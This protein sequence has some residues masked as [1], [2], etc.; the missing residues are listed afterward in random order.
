DGLRRALQGTRPAHRNV[1]ALGQDQ[2]PVIQA[3]A[4]ALLLV[5]EGVVTVPALETG[6]ASFLP[7]GEAP[8]EGLIRLVQASQHIL[9]D[10]AVD[11]RVFREGS[12]HLLQ[13][14][15][16]LEARRADALPAPPPRN[17]LFERAVVERAAAP[18][19]RFKL[20]LVGGR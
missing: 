11:V 4:V 10:V 8:E 6:K 20:T 15:F 17:A 1:P 16:L 13:L 5:G 12:A 2:I 3:R 18:Q 19:D 7:G 14:G 9:Q